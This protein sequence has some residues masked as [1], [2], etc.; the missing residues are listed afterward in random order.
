[1]LDARV[2]RAIAAAL[3]PDH[4]SVDP[5][6]RPSKPD[7]GDFQANFAMSLAKRLGRP[8]RDIASAVVDTLDVEDLCASV[9]IAGPGFVNLRLRTDW[10][11]DQANAMLGDAMLGVAAVPVPE[12]AVVDY[13][14][15]N[16]AK[17]MH[18]GHLRTTIIGDALARILAF[19]GHDVVR[20]NHVGDWGTPFGMLI[21]HL[22]DIGRAKAANELSV[23]NLSAF[24]Q[25]AR[26]KFDSDPDFAERARHRVVALQDGD[27]AT[28][29]LWRLLVEQSER[30]FNTVYE[31][32]G[33]LLTSEDYAGE[34]TYNDM[35]DDV[36]KELERSGLLVDSDGALCVFPPGFTGREG[37]PLPLIVRKRDGGYGYATTDLAAI[38]YRT[39]QLDASRLIYV[40]GR[41]QSLHLSMV[42]A[43]ARLAGW[44][45]DDRR[46]EHAAIGAV[47]GAD[48]KRL[49]TRSGESIK[50]IDLLEQAIARASRGLEDR[51]D[52]PAGERET[53][54]RQIGIGAVKYADLSVDRERDYLFNWDAMFALEGNTGPYLQYAVARIQSV[55]DRGGAT[56]TDAGKGHIRISHDT[57]R[58]LV[59]HALRF[60]R[61]VHAVS[62]TLQPHRLCGYLYDLAT[63]F[64]AFYEQ[65]PILRAGDELRTSRLALSVLV[66][67]TLTKGLHLLGID[68]PRRM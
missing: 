11:E 20:A 26:A 61:E 37:N 34:S 58:A 14:A 38:R 68:A 49:R 16:I 63:R 22:L 65:V 40:V 64:T 36:V 25:Q 54:A 12:R 41:E 24:Y 39:Q 47:R 67:R 35:L 32:L 30:Y 57:E 52:L 29:S 23:G 28:L 13:S 15:P 46:A 17:E 6:I 44:L 19:L 55:I 10:L 1:V 50:L 33:V 8:A 7:F 9:D 60:G 53:V 27:E 4:A 66:A 5:V 56:S 48:G 62:E 2:T 51:D 45:S 3:G 18:V 59:L 42:H 43:A 21:E 31:L